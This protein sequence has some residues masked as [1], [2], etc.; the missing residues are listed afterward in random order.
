MTDYQTI[1]TSENLTLFVGESSRKQACPACGKKGDFSVTKS[2]R[3]LVYR[4]WRVKCGIVGFIKTDDGDWGYVAKKKVVSK[5][6]PYI[7]EICQLPDKASSF[8]FKKFGILEVELRRNK[9]MWCPITKRVMYSILSSD[10]KVLGYVARI[11]KE[12]NERKCT[13]GTSKA[14]IFWHNKDDDEPSIAFPF[15]TKK[16][17]GKIVLVEDIPSAI[18]LARHTKSI[19]LMSNTIPANAL[20]YLSKYTVYIV[21]DEDATSQSIK[22]KEKYSLFFKECKIIAITK[23]PKDMSEIELSNQ[24]LEKLS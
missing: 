15:C 6:Y 1:I 4:C 7:G 17:E 9:V 5:R 18:R 8:L 24:I 20:S 19:A 21:L 10:N 22:L 16:C 3:G 12:I 13:I 14:K 11:Y 23:D 2:E